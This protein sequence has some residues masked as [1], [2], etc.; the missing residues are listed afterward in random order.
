MLTRDIGFALLRQSRATS[1]IEVLLRSEDGAG[2]I[3]R[4][5]ER[6]HFHIYTFKNNSVNIS[7]ALRPC[8]L[9]S[10]LDVNSDIDDKLWAF[11]L[12]IQEK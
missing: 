10:L 3:L 6:E 9:C 12:L 5:V 8:Q 7:V 2:I 4:F 11:T 1:W